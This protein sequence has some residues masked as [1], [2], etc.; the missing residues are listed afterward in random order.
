[1]IILT[2]H[3]PIVSESTLK[4]IHRSFP[5]PRK[6]LIKNLPLA[7]EPLLEAFNQ[8]GISPD[9]RP[10]DLALD[11]WQALAKICHNH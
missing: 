11:D 1:V 7:K 2:P 4:F 10:S 5:S 6:K 3:T 8:L 9:A